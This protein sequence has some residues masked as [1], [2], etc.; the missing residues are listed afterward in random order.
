MVGTRES[1]YE[2]MIFYFIFDL[3]QKKV[4]FK[5]DKV[6]LSSYVLNQPEY[7]LY[8]TLYHPKTKCRIKFVSHE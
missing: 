1:Y 8:F 7:Y 4:Q 3:K 5:G 6:S 2:G